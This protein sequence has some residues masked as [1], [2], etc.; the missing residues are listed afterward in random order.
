MGRLL[1]LAI[2]IASPALAHSWYPMVCCHDRDC[3]KVHAVDMEEVDDGCW[4]YRPT[5]VRFCGEQ[6]KPSQDKYWH[7]CIS[8]AGNPVCAFIQMGM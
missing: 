1:A 4:E 2:F 3:F 8:P 6:V 5:G 7:V